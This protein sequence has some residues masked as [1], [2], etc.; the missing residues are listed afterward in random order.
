M[1]SMQECAEYAGLAPDELDF[2]VAISRRHAASLASYLFNIHR[3]VVNVRQMII[4]D[5]WG[6]LDLGVRA[7]AC[8]TMV[9]LRMFLSN[10]P[11]ARRLP[12]AA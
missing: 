12:L 4:A 5:L 1:I 6:Y 2:D 3:G 10:F 8:D 11:E 9:V 7:K